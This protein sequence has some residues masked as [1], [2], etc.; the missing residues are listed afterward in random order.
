MRKTKEQLVD[1]L[2][3]DR[4]TNEQ[5]KELV[6]GNIKPEKNPYLFMKEELGSVY[7]LF[8]SQAGIRDRYVN[9]YKVLY[10]LFVLAIVVGGALTTLQQTES[11][12]V[13]LSAFVVMVAVLFMVAYQEYDDHKTFMKERDAIRSDNGIRFKKIWI[14]THNT[15]FGHHPL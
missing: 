5:L 6:N 9:F 4:L 1:L 10:Y 13:I 2:L 7:E 11:L 15:L 8:S 14:E 3:G 12:I